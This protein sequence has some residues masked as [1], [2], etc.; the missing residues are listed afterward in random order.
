MGFPW[1]SGIGP[2]IN[3]IKNHQL[4]DTF[5]KTNQFNEIQH[6]LN[7]VLDLAFKL[8]KLNLDLDLDDKLDIQEWTQYDRELEALVKRLNE[9]LKNNP[10]FAISSINYKGYSQ[11]I[12]NS[13]S[14]QEFETASELRLE[15]IKLRNEIL[16]TW[17]DYYLN[18]AEKLNILDQ[19]IGNKKTDTVRRY[20]EGLK[21]DLQEND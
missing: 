12:A 16:L 10:L 3:L 9:E 7:E 1:W 8:E 18:I 4:S 2:I 6:F 13:L 20:L 15:Q 19:K 17:V 14:K 5:V 11:D 21:Q